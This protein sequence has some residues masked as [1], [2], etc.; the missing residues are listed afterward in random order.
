MSKSDK[1]AS[2]YSGANPGGGDKT[3]LYVI[4]GAVVAVVILAV[5]AVLLTS[6]GGGSKSNASKKGTGAF[7]AA[8]AEREQAP[9]KVTGTP[10]AA[11][12]ESQ[13]VLVPPAQDPSC[14]SDATKARR[15]QFRWVQRD[16][17]PSRRTSEGHHLPRTLV[18]PLPERGATHPE[19]DQRG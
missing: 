6:S 18:P 1:P 19:L 5:V 15:C 4:I 14:G 11:Y 17:R 3:K 2:P 9:I 7:A 10:L 8:N 13:T 16:H 12:P